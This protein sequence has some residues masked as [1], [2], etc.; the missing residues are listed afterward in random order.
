MVI[1]SPYVFFGGKSKVAEEIWRRLGNVT[2]YVEPFLGS[3]AVWLA[4]PDHYTKI[5]SAVLNDKD[6]MIVNFWRA[7]QKE[8]E[9][10]ARYADAPAFESDLH[11]KHIWL[12]NRKHQLV[13]HLEGD[14]DFYDVKIAGWWVWGMSQWIGGGFCSGNGPWNTVDGKL[15]KNAGDAGGVKRQRLHTQ[16]GGHGVERRLLHAKDGGHGVSRKRIHVHNDGKGVKRV[17]PNAMPNIGIKRG[18]ANLD[19]LVNYF[20][21][22]AD[23]FAEARVTCGDWTRVITPSVMWGMNE[24]EP[25]LTGVVLDPPYSHSLRDTACYAEESDIDHVVRAW[26]LDNGHRSSLRI[27]YCTYIDEDETKFREAGWDI[28][29]WRTQG[30]MANYA[31][32]RGRDNKNKEVIYFSPHCIH[33]QKQKALWDE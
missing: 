15:T 20:Q 9:Q 25:A 17:L 19:A 5:R 6:G 4:H 27:A 10:V 13:E 18:G 32:G 23:K 3:A 21:T 16:D 8:P 1:K 7:M 12:V 26:A 14:P 31:N 28:Y 30:G 29:R 2:C 33:I 11:A 24:K 22:L